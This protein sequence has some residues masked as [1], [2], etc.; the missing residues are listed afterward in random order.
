MDSGNGCAASGY[1]Q[2]ALRATAGRADATARKPSRCR[3]SR[4]RINESRPWEKNPQPILLLWIAGSFQRL[5]APR[6][7]VGS[8]RAEPAC[9][10]VSDT[11]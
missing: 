4:V 1:V 7:T 11:T 5:A 6:R 3:G 2:L 8:A 10:S 9:L